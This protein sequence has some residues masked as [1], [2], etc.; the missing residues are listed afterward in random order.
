MSW[1][2][3]QQFFHPGLDQPF[4]FADHRMGGAAGE[5]A[6]HVG[7]DAEPALVVTALGDLEIAVVARGQ[8]DAAGGQ[9]VDERVG[10][11]RH[12]G[13]DGVQHGLVLMR[14]SDGEDFGV[15]FADIIRFRPQAAGDDDATVLGQR[16][17]DGLQRFRLG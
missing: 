16:L 9:Q 13:V 17:A 15:V 11:G 14:A 3:D 7:D 2:D 10:R 5:F 6:A 1:T 8:G 4:G 12:G